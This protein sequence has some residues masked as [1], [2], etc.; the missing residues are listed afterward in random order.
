MSKFWTQTLIGVTII[1][2]FFGWIRHVDA[3]AEQ[4]AQLLLNEAKPF[5]QS[6]YK[7]TF[8]YTGYYGTCDGSDSKIMT[9]GA[10]L[11]HELGVKESNNQ[12]LP[13]QPA[14]FTIRSEVEPGAVMT[15]TVASPVGQS[16]CYAV[17]RLDASGHVDQDHLLKWQEQMSTRLKDQ[18]IPGNW[19]VMMQGN[20]ASDVI[21]SQSNPKEFLKDLAHTYKGNVVESYE[22][23]TTYSLSLASTAFEGFITSGKHKVNVQIALHQDTTS[24]LW[25]LTVGT[26]VITMEY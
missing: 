12:V 3:Q 22:D 26:P 21:S 10:S 15:L 2:L 7:V 14:I 6:D 13:S 17:V 11:S 18:G 8:K 1:G 19:N 25:R 9:A 4:D 23:D 16:A 20:A 24:G 5:I